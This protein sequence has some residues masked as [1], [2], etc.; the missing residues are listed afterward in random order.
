MDEY[1]DC[2]E[3]Y[4]TL[5]HWSVV[6]RE[7][8]KKQHQKDNRI[9]YNIQQVNSTQKEFNRNV[10]ISNSPSMVDAL[11]QVRSGANKDVS[12]ADEIMNFNGVGIY[13]KK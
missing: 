2:P 3:Q 11:N 9:K 12:I 13:V 6:R 4:R 8:E 5:Q 1:N 10:T 7:L